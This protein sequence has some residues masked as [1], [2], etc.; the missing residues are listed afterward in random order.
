MDLNAASKSGLTI[1]R[2]VGLLGEVVFSS[3]EMR[4]TRLQAAFAEDVVMTH[5]HH[6]HSAAY[7]ER[8]F[9]VHTVCSIHVSY[10][11]WT[12]LLAIVCIVQFCIILWK[13]SLQQEPMPKKKLQQRY[14]NR[15]RLIT[16]SLA[17]QRKRLQ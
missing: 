15:V 13:V 17:A 2:C 10:V 16:L 1:I 4:A 3:T 14:E 9:C 11:V 12:V 6:H 5:A 7:R 8:F